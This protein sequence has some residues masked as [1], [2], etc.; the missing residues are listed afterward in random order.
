[1]RLNCNCYTTENWSVASLIAFHVFAVISQSLEWFLTALAG[2]DVVHLCSST[3]SRLVYYVCC[4]CLIGMAGLRHV[5]LA[6]FLQPL[7]KSLQCLSSIPEGK[8]SL[9]GGIPPSNITMPHCNSFAL[10]TITL[11]LPQDS[12]DIDWL[13]EI[14][15]TFTTASSA[16]QCRHKKD[17]E[18]VRQN[19]K[20]TE[21]VSQYLIALSTQSFFIC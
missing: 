5:G 3:S 18:W 14:C 21:K 13:E 19:T 9:K 15:G 6:S 4:D 12:P 10:D 16:A 2:T 17:R 1:M 11:W 7:T 20:H 8:F